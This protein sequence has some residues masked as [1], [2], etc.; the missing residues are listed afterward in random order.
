[1]HYTANGNHQVEDISGDRVLLGY[2]ETQV[3][4]LRTGK[5]STPVDPANVEATALWG[6]YLAYIAAN[7]SVRLKDLVTG[8]T[9]TLRRPGSIKHPGDF[10]IFEFGDYA[11]WS[12]GPGSHA[13]S[14]F[15]D[16]QH[17]RRVITIPGSYEMVALTS[18]GVLLATKPSLDGSPGYDLRGYSRHS[19]VR[20]VLRVPKGLE[21]YDDVQVDA[22]VLTWVKDGI[23]RAASL[24]IVADQPRSL[25]DPIAPMV[26]YSA[27]LSHC[28]FDFT[29]FGRVIDR[30]PCSRK[31]SPYGDA[32]VSWD[33]RTATG[34]SVR[35]GL[36]TWTVHARNASGSALAANGE[37][38]A[39]H[40]RI[41]VS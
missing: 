27:S 24:R 9:R 20:D 11:G 3:L 13:T 39:V 19:K 37:G 40:G 26:P 41:K 5:V 23:V 32:V 25:G 12:D 8:V 18:N 14:K 33:G 10:A 1:V 17:P 36:V 38:A 7:G 28:S 34:H 30:V 4:D 31:D 15:V 22:S 29:A 6:N 2:D 21:E 35:P 16:V